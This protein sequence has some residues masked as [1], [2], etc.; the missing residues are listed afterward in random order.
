MI[1]TNSTIA[2]TMTRNLS[3]TDSGLRNQSMHTPFLELATDAHGKRPAEIAE[4][5]LRGPP[6]SAGLLIDGSPDQ[7]AGHAASMLASVVA[8][9]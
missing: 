6:P 7:L 5:D 2:T 3:K 8:S 1:T 4:A 9:S